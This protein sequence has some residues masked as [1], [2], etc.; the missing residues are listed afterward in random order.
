MNKIN[1]ALLKK[2]RTKVNEVLG[3][4]GKELNLKISLGNMTYNDY[5]ATGKIKIEVVEN[6]QAMSVEYTDL[7]DFADLHKIDLDTIYK[8][9]GDPVIV[10][11]Y[12]WKSRKYPV[13]VTDLNTEK[14]FKV[15]RAWLLKVA[16]ISE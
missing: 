7:L 15:S 10:T 2:V 12:S 9:N 16:G 6:G 11:G 3:P 8:L 1:K 14:Q 13:F 4:V 5:N